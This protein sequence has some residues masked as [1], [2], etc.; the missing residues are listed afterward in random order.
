MSSSRYG[1]EARPDRYIKTVSATLLSI[2]KIAEGLLSGYVFTRIA[3]SVTRQVLAEEGDGIFASE[4]RHRISVG[5]ADGLKEAWSDNRDETAEVV[6][7][8]PL[9]LPLFGEL[10]RRRLDSAAAKVFAAFRSG[11]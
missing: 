9:K 7:S 10:S 8:A 11:S 2:V 3:A 1:G 5:T 6:R 4:Y